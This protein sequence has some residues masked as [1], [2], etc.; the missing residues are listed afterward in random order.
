[1]RIGE[2][3]LAFLKLGLTSFGGPIAH[4]GYFRDEF[5]VRRRWLSDEAYGE[6]LALS[7]FLPGPASS[8]TGFILGWMRGG[9][10]GAVAAWIA[11][12]A[13]SVGL[14]LIFAG[15]VHLASGA[16][17]NGALH[18]LKL[19]AVVIV[20]QA[21]WG[22]AGTLAPDSRRRLIAIG[23]VL[24]VL[25]ANSALAHLLV[26]LF[27]AIAGLIFCRNI[28]LPGPQA[29]RDSLQ[30]LQISPLLGGLSLLVF[31]L[32]LI[33]VPV[34]GLAGGGGALALFD[35]FYRA[36]ALVF[37]GGHVVLPLLE[38]ELV[39]AG[40]VGADQFL[41]G[42]GAAQALPGPLF[43]FAA[44][45][46]V[47]AQAPLPALLVGLICLLAIFLPGFLLVVGFV[48]FWARLRKRRLPQAAL[49]GV[50]AAVVG[51]LAAALYDPV[52]LGAVRE[53]GDLLLIGAGLMLLMGFRF[54]P[55]AIVLVLV[56]AGIAVEQI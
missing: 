32:L 24:G 31:V 49:S 55:W 44:Y 2:V 35:V 12:T 7:Q 47:V 1:M 38:A 10:L 50:N 9:P 6:I 43:S 56:L 54:P 8:Q 25:L 33:A 29:A 15:V 17:V 4:L 23:A 30:P 51:I 40:W 53:A 14:L 48:P 21:L 16:V 52:A 46:G 45:L 27:G 3:F 42:Y 13:P 18:G 36:G 39:P 28:P 20:A 5:V 11:F 22:M 19:V 41:A 34:L 37:G 26:I